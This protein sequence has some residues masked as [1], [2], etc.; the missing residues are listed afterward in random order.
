MADER[1]ARIAQLE[2]ELRQARDEIE[3]RDRALNAAQEEKA[4][5]A[6]IL[7]TIASSPT[8][9]QRVLDAVVAGAIELGQAD[10]A[11]ILRAEAGGMRVVASTDLTG[12]SK[13]SFNA[14]LYFDNKTF[15]A[16][17][18]AAYRSDY[19]TTVPGRNGNDVEGT[20]STLNVDFSSSYNINENLSVSLEALNLTDE[21]DDQWV[22]SVGNRLSYYHHQG[23]TY[24]V[25]ARFKY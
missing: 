16:R 20:A 3:R 25:G 22:D 21:V 23:R 6:G 13:N 5:T 18:A 24:F 1:D 14:T 11:T 15:S 12:L 4:A 10:V 17:V 8:D 9:P 2:A 7:R 19:L